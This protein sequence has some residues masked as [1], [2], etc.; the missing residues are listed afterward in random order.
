[1]WARIIKLH[2]LNLEIHP[3]ALLKDLRPF[4]LTL[5][6]KPM[7]GKVCKSFHNLSTN[8]NL[9]VKFKSDSLKGT[10]APRVFKD[11]LWSSFKRGHALEITGVHKGKEES[12]AFLVTTTP[13]QA[14]KIEELQ[15]TLGSEIVEVK[16][17]IRS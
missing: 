3:I 13:I 14:K 17:A 16:Q 11:V 15:I 2:L 6:N 10:T 8:T 7:I 12:F 9:S 4:I 1:M 5:C